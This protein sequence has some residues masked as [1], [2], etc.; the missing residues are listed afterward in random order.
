MRILNLTNFFAIG[1]L[2]LAASCGGSDDSPNDGNTNLV[3]NEN[4]AVEQ[5]LSEDSAIELSLLEEGVKVQ[6]AQAITG[7][8][9]TPNSNIDFSL[10]ESASKAFQKNGINISFNSTA[11]VAGAYIQFKD[12]NDNATGNYFDVPESSFTFGDSGRKVIKRSKKKT[13]RKQLKNLTENNIVVDFEDIIPAGEFCFDICIYDAENNISQIIERCVTVEAWGG[14]ASIVGEWVLESESED[15]V[16]EA[17]QDSIG[18]NELSVPNFQPENNTFSFFCDNGNEIEITQPNDTEV[19]TLVLNSDG[20]YYETYIGNNINLD[21]IKTGETCE[22]T[23]V[24][25]AFSDRYFGNW[26]YDEDNEEL[27][28]VDFGYRDLTDASENEDYPDGELYIE[29]AKVTVEGNKL[30]ITEGGYTLVFARK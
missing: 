13:S 2:C 14:N 1:A 7:T 26:A 30:T 9:P 17:V 29:A 27:T 11:N 6:G 21:D 23:F 15:N 24:N 8:P 19:H 16:I 12:V 10:N 28:I 22:P 18:D 25:D 20:S 3:G 5:N 4:L